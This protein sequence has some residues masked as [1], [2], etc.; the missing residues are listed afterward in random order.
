MW[1]TLIGLLD[2]ETPLLGVM[3][4]PFTGERFWSAEKSAHMRRGTGKAVTLKT[5]ACAKLRGCHPDLD[6]SRTFRR[7]PPA[8]R[9]RTL[10]ASVRMTRYGGDCYGYCLLAAGFIDLI[11]E[12][13]LKSYDV[14]A[15]I[16]IVERAGGIMTTWDG[17]PAAHGGDIIACGDKRLH[18][19]ALKVLAKG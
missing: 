13:D 14:A 9:A 3:D 17:K 15:L 19:A 11:I 7:R 18:A 2:G 8:R 16:P 10:K 12:P 6:P 5:R 4:Q 1:G